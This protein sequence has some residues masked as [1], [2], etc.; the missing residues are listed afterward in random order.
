MGMQQD[1]R[2]VIEAAVPGVPVEWGWNRQ[3]IAAPRVVLTLVSGADPISHD[4]P[5]GLIERRVQVDVFAQA[6]A[7]VL[8]AGD[9]IRRAVSGFYQ[10]AI[11][12]VT[13]IGV[14]DL[15]PESPGGAVLARYSMDLRV[16]Y[17]ED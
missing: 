17:Q 7:D 2:A 14:R 6:Y 15:P 10:G 12:L 4:G 3:G 13:V 8:D 1:L 16:R 5:T 9:A 11:A